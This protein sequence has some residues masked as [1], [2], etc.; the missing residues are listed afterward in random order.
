M[1]RTCTRSSCSS[2]CSSSSSSST[3]EKKKCDKGYK[4]RK[5]VCEKPCK[6]KV[7]PCKGKSSSSSTSSS[8][9]DET[10]KK[11]KCEITRDEKGAWV[12]LCDKNGPE[13]AKDKYPQPGKNYPIKTTQQPAKMF[14]VTLAD[15]KYHHQAHRIEDGAKVWAVNGYVGARI[16]LRR[17]VTY[18][19][20]VHQSIDDGPLQEFYFTKD[21]EG[22]YTDNFGLNIEG[23]GAISSGVICIKVTDQTPSCFYYQSKQGSFRG[24]M[25]VVHN[26]KSN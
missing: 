14:E 25:V 4:P 12:S 11:K 10:D 1:G 26:A 19:F 3:C 24:G 23:T 18:Y 8:S 16:N 5:E 9:S 2:S 15:K 7:K 17:G 20:R 22:G 21:I 6:L 13:H